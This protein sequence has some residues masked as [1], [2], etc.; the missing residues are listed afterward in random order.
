LP[1]DAVSDLPLRSRAKGRDAIIGPIAAM[2]HASNHIDD[3]LKR[4]CQRA[5]AD[6]LEIGHVEFVH[7]GCHDFCVHR[8]APYASRLPERVPRKIHRPNRPVALCFA[9]HRPRVPCRSRRRPPS[10]P[11]RTATTAVPTRAG[12]P[13][14]VRATPEWQPPP[15]TAPQLQLWV[16]LCQDHVASDR[17][18]PPACNRQGDCR[19]RQPADI[20]ALIRCTFPVPTPCQRVSQTLKMP[21]KTPMPNT[22][23]RLHNSICIPVSTVCESHSHPPII[24][25]SARRNSARAA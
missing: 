19:P 25:N 11:P 5:A 10:A 16:S 2:R 4:G 20:S 15:G 9:A 17:Y 3:L 13:S 12:K 18:G 8:F 23:P 22:I 24:L 21:I 7:I 6:G 1:T 14:A